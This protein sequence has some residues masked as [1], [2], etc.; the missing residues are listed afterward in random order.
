WLRVDDDPPTVTI[1]LDEMAQEALGEVVYADL[2]AVGREVR[3]GDALGS[4]EAEKMVRPVLA[5]LSGTVADVN[6]AVLAAPRL[7]NSDPYGGGWL[8]KIRA[9]RWAAEC[10]ELLHGD[11]AVVAWARAELERHA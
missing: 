4:L 6:D 5:P 3:R 1:G 9:T 7:L 10:H 8:F 2:A 11:D